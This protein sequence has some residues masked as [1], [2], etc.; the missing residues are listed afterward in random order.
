[1]DSGKL[2]KKDGIAI[3]IIEGGKNFLEVS[4]MLTYDHPL[5]NKASKITL[6]KNTINIYQDLADCDLRECIKKERVEFNKAKRWCF[7][8]MSGL[9]FLHTEG[10]V[11]G[12]IKPHNILIF[13]DKVKICDFGGSFLMTEGSKL[14]SFTLKYCAPE[15]LLNGDASFASDV[16]SLGCVFYE[17]LTG[18][19]LINQDEDVNN[20]KLKTKILISIQV[21][22]KLEG[23]KI[24]SKEEIYPIT[25]NPIFYNKSHR[26][27]INDMMRYDKD[28]R[29]TPS[30]LLEHRWFD[31]MVGQYKGRLLCNIIDSKC[32]RSRFSDVVSYLKKNN[33]GLPLMLVNK[34]ASIYSRSSLV[35][36]EPI[37]TILKIVYDLYSIGSYDCESSHD[38]TYKILEDAE[39]RIHKY[40]D[41]ELFV[42]IDFQ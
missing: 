37:G 9:H 18:S 32:Y 8:M 25:H 35:G 36:D 23:D 42:A 13:G 40:A 17:L 34:I 19:Q 15:V 4:I 7:D 3:K 12:D 21:W 33:I 11:H 16:W 6:D 5:L 38:L 20:A 30:D 24:P 22:R 41:D 39:F 2:I 14:K 31:G 27:I 29:L 1:M 28:K 26:T 10:I